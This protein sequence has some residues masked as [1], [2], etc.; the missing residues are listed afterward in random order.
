MEHYQPEFV[1]RFLAENADCT[2]PACQSAA[3][4]SPL[5]QVK[6][7]NQQRD[8]LDLRCESAARQVLLN[9]K[10]FVLHAEENDEQADAPAD[11]WLETLN[12][13]CL[14]LAMHPALTVETAL[15]AIGI[16]LSKAKQY[17][18][19]QQDDSSLLVMMAEQIGHLGEEGV[20]AEQY[21]QLPQIG[22]VETEALKTLGTHR[23]SF[24][25]PMMEKMA[26]SLKVGELVVMNDAQLADRV[27]ALNA[28]WAQA[29]SDNALVWMAR[30]VLIYQLYHDIFPGSDSATYGTKMLQLAT[31]FFQLK[32]LLAIWVET[33][34]ALTEESV[35]S[36][37]SSWKQL[38]A[39]TSSPLALKS[40]DDTAL[41]HAL[42]LI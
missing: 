17:Q 11:L 29:S 23:I 34:N 32:M 40:D 21:A 13:Q 9:P 24:N 15:Y 4:G 27:T 41:L 14:N 3:E 2:C 31:Q 7:N 16:L 28:V 20:L 19:T 5:I 6:F 39:T 38:P 30:N 33:G 36:L 22:S 10:A 42:S 18:Q 8:S 35:V 1:L 12:Q 37:F 25:L 26:V